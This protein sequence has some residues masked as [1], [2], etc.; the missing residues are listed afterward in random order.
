MN[1]R[2]LLLFGVAS[3]VLLSV[4]SGAAEPIQSIKNPYFYEIFIHGKA[5]TGVVVGREATVKFTGFDLQEDDFAKI[6]DERSDSCSTGIPAGGVPLMSMAHVVEDGKVVL[7]NITVQKE[8]YYRVCYKHQ[9]VWVE[10]SSR[11]S[12][13]DPNDD[14][15]STEPPITTSTPAPDP[16]CPTLPPEEQA[17]MEKFVGIK[18]G[19]ESKWNLQSFAAPVRE[20]LCLPPQNIVT[21]RVAKM[22]SLVYWY[23]TIECPS[24]KCNPEERYNYLLKYFQSSPAPG[25]SAIVIRSVEGLYSLPMDVHTTVVERRSGILFLITSLFFLSGGALFLFTMYKYRERQEHFGG[26]DSSFNLGAA[27]IEDLFPP[28]R[29]GYAMH[30]D[31]TPAPVDAF[32][33]V[34]E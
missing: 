13:P 29:P 3:L 16:N 30:D 21:I 27:D 19:V 6:V 25:K 12:D 33:E 7:W 15:E 24:E 5:S 20:I 11:G 10:V 4:S 22:D 9:D 26:M 28:E 34:E 17:Q 1:S 8:G 14:P 31:D 32:I 2:I 23:F 18:M